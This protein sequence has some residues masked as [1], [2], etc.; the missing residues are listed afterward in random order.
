MWQRSVFSGVMND[1]QSTWA[2]N[3]TSQFTTSYQTVLANL[4]STGLF[5]NSYSAT[6]L[7]A[8]RTETS[9]PEAGT[10]SLLGI[11]L[12]GLAAALQPR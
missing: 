5:S 3:F 4:Q 7:V 11:G 12:I 6:I 9:V 10:M 2:G 1:G 8:T